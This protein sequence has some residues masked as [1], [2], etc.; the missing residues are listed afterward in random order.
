M[1]KII[2]TIS[3]IVLNCNFVKNKKKKT[4]TSE[5]IYIMIVFQIQINE[6][7]FKDDKQKNGLYG[8]EHLKRLQTGYLFIF[9]Y[10]V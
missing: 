3:K 5:L 9:C 10:T 4:F 1:L 8:V 6:S 7:A 2:V